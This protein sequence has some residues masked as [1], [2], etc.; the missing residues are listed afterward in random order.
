MD[1][2]ELTSSLSGQDMAKLIVGRKGTVPVSLHVISE[3]SEIRD[4]ANSFEI[5]SV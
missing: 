1:Q 5:S 2:V 4:V 3:M